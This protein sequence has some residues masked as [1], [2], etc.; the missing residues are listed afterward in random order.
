M[1][2]HLDKYKG[3][4]DIVKDLNPSWNEGEE[5]VRRLLESIGEKVNVEAL[6]KMIELG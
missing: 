6:R 4:R 5:K 2:D 1:I 3:K